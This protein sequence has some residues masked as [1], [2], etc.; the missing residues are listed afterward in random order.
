V[1]RFDD[2]ATDPRLLLVESDEAFAYDVITALSQSDES[3]EVDVVEN[4]RR[5][6]DLAALDDHDIVVID[7]QGASTR[8]AAPAIRRLRQATSATLIVLS[9]LRA[10]AESAGAFAAGADSFVVKPTEGVAGVVRAVR[11]AVERRWASARLARMAY[12]D[13]LTGLDNRARFYQSVDAA[14]QGAGPHGKLAV[15]FI[16]LDGFKQV[17]DVH[18]HLVGDQVLRQI[19]RR[20]QAR[21]SQ[22]GVRVGRLG[23]DEFALLVDPIGRLDEAIDVAEAVVRTLAEPIVAAGV[24]H[25]VGC[26]CGVAIRPTS[27]RTTAELLR[28]ADEA[29]YAAKQGG[30]AIRVYLPD[31]TPQWGSG[32]RPAET[33]LP[34]P[35]AAVGTGISARR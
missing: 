21:F 4:V 15:L 29:M 1:S 35:S 9:N 31:G 34:A 24:E 22:P 26:C 14:I 8:T 3:I 5:A 12:R 11:V 30:G 10:H 17:N 7:L 28:G 19:G 16:D 18:G 13:A 23:G 27:G 6:T 25:R 33:P 32:N 2:P 20:L